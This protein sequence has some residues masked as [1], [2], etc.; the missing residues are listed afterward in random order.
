MTE[1]TAVDFACKMLD[2]QKLD[3]ELH[4]RIKAA[5][6]LVVKVK[7]GGALCSTQAIAVIVDQWMRERKEG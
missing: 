2:C 5:H 6:E 3:P 4:R 1:Q 7:P